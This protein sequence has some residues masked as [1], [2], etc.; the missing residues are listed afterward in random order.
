MGCAFLV[1]KMYPVI[2]AGGGSRE[3]KQSLLSTM[4]SFAA[5]L[6]L[7]FDWVFCILTWNDNNK[8]LHDKNVSQAL[9]CFTIIATLM[10]FIYVSNGRILSL[11]PDNIIPRK[12]NS[13]K[14]ALLCIFLEDIPQLVL[15]YLIEKEFTA[16]GMMNLVS[17]SYDMILKLCET[18][19]LRHE[20]VILKQLIHHERMSRKKAEIEM[21][22]REQARSQ[23]IDTRMKDLLSL[24][25][26]LI[27]NADYYEAKQKCGEGSQMLPRHQRDEKTPFWMWSRKIL[28][29]MLKS[30][31]ENHESCANLFGESSVIFEE[32]K[33]SGLVSRDTSCLM[34]TGFL[35]CLTSCYEGMYQTRYD[36]YIIQL[37]DFRTG[38]LSEED[39]V[40]WEFTSK[41]IFFEA[42]FMKQSHVIDPERLILKFTR[43]IKSAKKKG[44]H[45]HILAHAHHGIARLYFWKMNDIHAA[46]KHLKISYSSRKKEYKHHDVRYLR[47]TLDFFMCLVMSCKF[48]QAHKYAI[49]IQNG[50]LEYNKYHNNTFPVSYYRMA[51]KYH[52]LC[53]MIPKTDIWESVS[54]VHAEKLLTPHIQE[55]REFWS[56]KVMK[57]N[58][59]NI[60]NVE[61]QY[62]FAVYYHMC[63][64]KG[65]RNQ[66]IRDCKSY[67][68]EKNMYSQSLVMNKANS[69]LVS[70]EST[71][72]YLKIVFSHHIDEE[73]IHV[74]V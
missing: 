55:A 2:Y 49:E 10:W 1:R 59:K 65:A 34:M 33:R 11:L 25:Q 47:S 17:S 12:M 53:A 61:I 40:Y 62:L 60:Y 31:N 23:G 64:N 68:N 58:K 70:W 9:L 3:N 14:I 27:E 19:E 44:V 8:S 48:R 18:M 57:I 22:L 54:F 21:R 45:G 43:F 29:S 7:V 30:L 39:S 74:S 16:I 63:R 42:D 66:W 36:A 32:M 35:R 37:Q 24:V 26:Y 28:D 73:Q 15:T 4:V 72:E 67:G 6:D 69:A 38:Y 20:E 71:N 46:E 52:I 56:S 13:G 41:R 50:L 51:C 5:D